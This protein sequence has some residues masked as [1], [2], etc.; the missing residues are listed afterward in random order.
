MDL[1]MVCAL[2]GETL[3]VRVEVMD[4][5]TEARASR[6]VEVVGR[7]DPDDPCP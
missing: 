5:R 7:S 1:E 2:D 6:V 4:L 3:R